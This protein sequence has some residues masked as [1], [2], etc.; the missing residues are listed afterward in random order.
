MPKTDVFRLGCP[1]LFVF[2]AK[3]LK[4]AQHTSSASFCFSAHQKRLLAASGVGKERSASSEIGRT[5]GQLILMHGCTSPTSL[6]ATGVKR[7]RNQSIAHVGGL[8]LVIEF[9]QPKDDGTLY[10]A[11]IGRIDANVRSAMEIVA[12]KGT[13]SGR[14]SIKTFNIFHR[15]DPVVGD[16]K[17]TKPVPI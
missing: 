1:F 11:K 16:I 3:R 15:N 4:G 13:R 12:N 14:V 5:N 7:L 9:K 17:G 10:R 6:T 8:M 2:L